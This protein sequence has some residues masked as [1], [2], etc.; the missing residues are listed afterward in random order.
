MIVVTGGKEEEMK[1]KD[2]IEKLQEY[3]PNAETGIIVHNYK[4]EFS[5]TFG[6]GSEGELKQDTK[7]VD[8]YVDRLCQSEVSH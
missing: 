6:G 4:E 3:N 5:I 8:F 1:V 2:L 7:E